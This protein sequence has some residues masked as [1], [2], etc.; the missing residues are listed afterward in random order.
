[1]LRR[2]PKVNTRTAV[3]SATLEHIEDKISKLTRNKAKV[4]LRTTQ[5][6]NNKT[7]STAI[8]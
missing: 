1:V 5:I 7:V 8:P 4:V 2:L 6:E 3:F